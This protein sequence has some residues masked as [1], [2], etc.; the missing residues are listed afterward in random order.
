MPEPEVLDPE[1]DAT[2]A[3][4]ENL[5]A[6]YRH[7]SVPI[8]INELAARKGEAIEILEARIQI[9]ETARARAIRMTAPEDW[10]LF[11]SP[12]ERVT[13]YLQDAGCDR[14]RDIT[15]IEVFAISEP[16]REMSQD[17]KSFMYLIRGN[18]R[19]RLTLQVVE[20]MEGGRMSTDDFC[21]DKQGVALELAVRKAARANLDGNIVRELAGLKTVPLEDLQKAWEGTGKNWEHCRKG[22]GFGT[23]E[24]RAGGERA[25]AP[26]LTP[27][28]CDVCGKVG[29]F[30]TSARGGFYGCSDW[31]AHQDRKWSVDLKDWEKDPRSTA[32]AAPAAQTPQAQASQAKAST[33]QASQPRLD[34]QI[35]PLS[36]D[37]I[38]FGSNPPRRTGR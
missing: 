17:G 24:E 27:P 10:V 20:D 31:K 22:R 29:V 19:S 16:R 32:A 5:P 37:D 25:D 33:Q 7:P 28:N 3:T 11:K 14:I 23:K 13:G 36:D 34:D 12:D 21:K 30:R 35:P 6:R 15:G 2:D 26:K 18:G 8:S 9:L 4:S 1:T 38:S